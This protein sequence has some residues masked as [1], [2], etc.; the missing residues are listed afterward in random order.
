MVVTCK[1]VNVP[2]FFFLLA[3]VL[4]A[5][6]T[7]APTAE[8]QIVDVYATS[9]AQ[10]WLTKLYVCAADLSVE[11][12]VN[13]ESPEIYLRVGDFED[14]VSP[15]YQIG[16]EEVLVVVPRESPVQSLTL[17]QAQDLFAQENP[18]S[19]VWVYPSDANMQR[20]FDQLVMQG[21]S[22]SSSARVAGSPQN[23]SD[24]LK[25]DPSAIGILPRHWVTGD[26]R[27][28]F[29]A[30]RVPVFAVT[31]DEPQG[32]VFELISCLQDN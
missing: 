16:E 32:V 29:L 4:S 1:H 2:I 20:V 21:R 15:S 30:A 8:P 25:S 14:F 9:A 5:C 31:K 17:A 28:V 11:L 19:Q 22:V 24:V 7:A 3:L 23:M 13:A 12:N 10:P 26:M 27:E 18:P 6:G